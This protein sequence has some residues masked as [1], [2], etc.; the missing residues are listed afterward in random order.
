[1]RATL[2][3]VWLRIWLALGLVASMALLGGSAA[4]W[5]GLIAIPLVPSYPELAVQLR[6]RGTVAVAGSVP[7]ALRR[8]ETPFADYRTHAGLRAAL[9]GR[10]GAAASRALADGHFDG[11]MVRTDSAQG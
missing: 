3:R 4:W 1:M 10:D 8:E 9:E 11:L 5:R 6:D 2:H 7:L